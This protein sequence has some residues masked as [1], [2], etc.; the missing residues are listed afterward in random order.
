MSG[1]MYVLYYFAL[2]AQKHGKTA[3]DMKSQSYFYIV[4]VNFTDLESHHHTH[5]ETTNK[6]I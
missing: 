3:N 6:C 2:G 1:K 4:K 5:P